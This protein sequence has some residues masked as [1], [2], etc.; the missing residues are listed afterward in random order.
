M[1]T[2]P[3]TENVYKTYLAGATMGAYLRVKIDSAGAVVLAGATD[4]TAGYLTERGATSGAH[5]TVRSSQAPEQIGVANAAL[6]I[7]DPLFAAANGMVD[8]AD[9]GSARLI[10]YAATT[11]TTQ[12]DL[13]RIISAV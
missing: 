7:G 10:G 1:S 11:V 6:E 12:G 4:M 5:C 8:D 9:A 3:L 13:V 2:L